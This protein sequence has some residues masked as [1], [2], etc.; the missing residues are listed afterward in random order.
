M[1]DGLLHHRVVACEAG[2]LYQGLGGVRMLTLAIF[3]LREPGEEFE[4][5]PVVPACRRTIE[6]P[7][8][9][10]GGGKRMLKGPVPLGGVIPMVGE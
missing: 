8:R 2:E 7:A 3:G 6:K 5:P 10:L 1:L 9:P 4:G